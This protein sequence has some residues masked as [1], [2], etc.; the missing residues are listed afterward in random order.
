MK[1]PMAVVQSSATIMPAIESI[2]VAAIAMPYRPP[3][4]CA[5]QIAMH[6]AITGMAVDFI[7][8]PRPAMMLVP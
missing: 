3:S 8:M 6:T 1:K 7:E 2:A 4:A 5:P